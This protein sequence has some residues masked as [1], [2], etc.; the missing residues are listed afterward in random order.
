MTTGDPAF[1][2]L[3]YSEQGGARQVIGGEIDIV[4]GGALK[5][6]GVATNIVRGSTSITGATGG[7]II[8]GLTTVSSVVAVLGE[9]AGLAGDKVTAAIGGTAGHITV[10]VWKPT[11]SGDCTPILATAAKVVNWVAVGT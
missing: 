4:A 8:T 11:A 7:D 2:T 3:N 6:S 10:K 1:N 9:D 5:M